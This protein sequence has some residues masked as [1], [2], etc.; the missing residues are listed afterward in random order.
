VH[1][2]TVLDDANSEFA[3]VTKAQFLETLIEEYEN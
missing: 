3:M 2:D 1:F